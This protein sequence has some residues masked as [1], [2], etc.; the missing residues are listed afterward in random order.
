MIKFEFISA[1]GAREL[2]EQVNAMRA[3]GGLA[4]FYDGDARSLIVAAVKIGRTGAPRILSWSLR[5]PVTQ[6]EA[7]RELA[8]L[9]R[10]RH[11]P[12]FRPPTLN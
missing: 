7:A 8:A 3:P 12:G 11:A 10:E 5:G 4:A 9:A 2:S 6:P 1:A